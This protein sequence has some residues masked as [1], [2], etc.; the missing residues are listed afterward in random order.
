MAD[1][2]DEIEE[3]Y[4]PNQLV[5][6]DEV[7]TISAKQRLQIDYLKER[8]RRCLDINADIRGDNDND[9]RQKKLVSYIRSNVT[10]HLTKSLV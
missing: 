10:E 8:L 5:K 9:E 2:L 1:Y 6:F 7:I 3:Q 4:R